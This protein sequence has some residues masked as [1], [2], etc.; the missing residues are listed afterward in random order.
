[1]QYVYDNRLESDDLSFGQIVEQAVSQLEGA[2]ACVFK[3]SNFAGEVIAARKGSPLLIGIKTESSLPDD[4]PITF[5][6]T[7]NIEQQKGLAGLS[8][9]RKRI[10]S[11]QKI[12]S[13][14][15]NTQSGDVSLFL[16]QDS[17]S[18]IS[19]KVFG[20]I[21]KTSFR[22]INFLAS[23]LH[24]LNYCMIVTSFVQLLTHNIFNFLG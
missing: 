4:L 22:I 1:M 12:D 6:N 14:K 13:V 15:S 3:S 18:V 17:V 23:K 24:V 21:R 9:M 11:Q 7:Q 2:F 20:A 16:G 10:P 19:K 8:Q 5:N